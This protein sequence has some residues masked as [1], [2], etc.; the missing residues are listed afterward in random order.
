MVQVRVSFFLGGF[1]Y[2]KIVS[3]PRLPNLADELI[4]VFQTE[5]NKNGEHILFSVDK[6]FPLHEGDDLPHYSVVTGPLGRKV[7]QKSRSSSG[8]IINPVGD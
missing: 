3:L 4:L 7:L 2:S 8:W 5:L 1:Y 6:V